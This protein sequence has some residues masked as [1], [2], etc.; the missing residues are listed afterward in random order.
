MNEQKSLVLCHNAIGVHKR[1]VL[2][3]AAAH[4]EQPANVVEFCEE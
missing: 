3:V 4:V 2:D 1:V